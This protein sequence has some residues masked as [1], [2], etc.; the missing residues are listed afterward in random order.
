MWLTA[1][2]RWTLHKSRAQVMCHV[3]QPS[4]WQASTAP[5]HA[6]QRAQLVP[7]RL[8]QH[9]PAPATA[10]PQQVTWRCYGARSMGM[11]KTAK[12]YMPRDQFFD[13]SAASHGP[14]TDHRITLLVIAGAPKVEFWRIPLPLDSSTPPTRPSLVLPLLERDPPLR[15]FDESFSCSDAALSCKQGFALG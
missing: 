5:D 9:Q 4:S 15:T 10:G 8:S 14:G 2:P 1:C 11:P 12:Q 7:D 3:R 6:Q 13:W